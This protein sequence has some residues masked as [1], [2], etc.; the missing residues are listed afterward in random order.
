VANSGGGNFPVH[1]AAR[2]GHTEIVRCLAL[3]GC[4]TD[5]KNSDGITPDLEAIANGNG[6]VSDLLKRL[7]RDS[8]CDD[9]IEQLIPSP[10]P[11]SKIK[12]KIFGKS[13]VGKTSLVE[14]LKAGY[15]TGLF[16]RSKRTS[17]RGKKR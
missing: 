3:A 1:L 16:R 17:G 2:G 7:K 10:T 11:I 6:E 4:K 13:A 15:L 8:C 14:S 12:L 5:A 9:Y